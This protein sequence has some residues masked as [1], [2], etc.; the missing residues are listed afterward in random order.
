MLHTTQEIIIIS[1]IAYKKFNTLKTNPWIILLVFLHSSYNEGLLF[2]ISPYKRVIMLICP[3]C[4]DELG[5]DNACSSC[6]WV[7]ANIDGLKNFLGEKTSDFFKQYIKNY[8]QIANDDLNQSIQPKEYLVN[9]AE[10]LLS[11]LSLNHADNICDI[12]GGQGFLVT[13]LKKRGFSKL[14]IVDIAIPYLKILKKDYNCVIADAEHLPFKNEFD[15]IFS[16]DVLEHVINIGSFLYSVNNALV[17]NGKFIVRVPLEENL[18]Q[19]S[20]HLGC[21]YDFVHLRTFTKELLRKT[22]EDAGFEIERF[23]YDSYWTYAKKNYLSR[24]GFLNKYIAYIIY[25]LFSKASYVTSNTFFTRLMCRIFLK[26]IEI[27]CVAK[28]VK[29]L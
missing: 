6:S 3:S 25:R 23:S 27:I 5:T 11:H 13:E 26:P 12:G 9:Q 14:T 10:H 29:T 2:K 18:M 28:K 24:F 8:D 20:K 16:T 7:V 22:L 4:R 19:Y 15:V 21:P 17:D 1:L